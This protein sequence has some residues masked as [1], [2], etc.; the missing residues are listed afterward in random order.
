MPLWQEAAREEGAAAGL[1]GTAIGRV[2]A[3][4]APHGIAVKV[5]PRTARKNR[6]AEIVR[7]R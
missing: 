2:N 1:A 7:M 3:G 6:V 5:T 4:C